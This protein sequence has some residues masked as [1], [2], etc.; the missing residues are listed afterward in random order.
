MP[1][2]PTTPRVAPGGNA[3][4]TSDV[5]RQLEGDCPLH[6]KQQRWGTNGTMNKLLPLAVGVIATV[7]GFAL[8]AAGVEAGIALLVVALAAVFFV[9]GSGAGAATGD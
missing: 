7:G 5:V 8:I 3:A 6:A 1:G 2:R 9:P 4:V